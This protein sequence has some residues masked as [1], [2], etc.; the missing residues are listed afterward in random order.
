MSVS[1]VTLLLLCCMSFLLFASLVINAIALPA[2]SRLT[3]QLQ[4]TESRLAVASASA[5]DLMRAE[6][7]RELP[8]IHYRNEIEVEIK[9]VYPLLRFLG[10]LPDDL[11]VRVNIGIQ[12]GRQTAQ[13]E[14]D[15]ILLRDNQP[16]AVVEAKA[17]SQNLTNE[18]LAQARSYAYGLGLDLYIVT[19]GRTLEIWSRG[20]QHDSRVVRLHVDELKEH[21]EQ[22]RQIIGK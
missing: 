15:W 21:W 18:V 5:L 10:Y 12:V 2:N 13:T 6:W 3:K 11:R 14:A 22:L 1:D 9:F 16:F 19:N 17:V 4:H 20:T 7:L 8:H